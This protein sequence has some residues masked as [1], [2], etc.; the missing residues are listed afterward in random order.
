MAFSSSTAR[1]VIARHADDETSGVLIARVLI[2]VVLVAITARVGAEMTGGAQHVH[3]AESAP[4][5]HVHGGV[6]VAGDHA[7][8]GMLGA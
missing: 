4:P 6:A 7:M 8:P 2:V 3:D 5:G 1:R